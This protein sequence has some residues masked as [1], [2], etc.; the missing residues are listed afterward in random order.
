[1]FL[2]IS[3]VIFAIYIANV[4]LGATGGSPFVGDVSEMLLLFAAVI[5]FVIAI[6]QREAAEKKKNDT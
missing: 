2:I 5:A 6:L 1:M 3:A 4:F